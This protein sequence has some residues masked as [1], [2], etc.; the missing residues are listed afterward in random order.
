MEYR[1][2][3]KMLGTTIEI[4]VISDDWHIERRM[5]WIFDFFSSFEQEFSRF[6]PH[7]TLSM[8][9]TYKKWE[10]T[11]RFVKLLELSKELFKKT[12]WYFN[13]LV[14]ISA[15]GYS[16]D[17]E[18]WD[19]KK[20]IRD[21]N[22]DFENIR[23]D[24]KT[25]YLGENQ[26]LDFG[27]IWKWYAVDLASKFLLMFGYDNFFINAWWDIYGNGKMED[28]NP[29]SIWLENPFNGQLMWQVDL[30]NMAIATS[31][32]YIRNW[33]IGWE[34][35]HHILNP[36]S[37]KNDFAMA[38]VTVFAPTW[39]EA[40]AFTKALFNMDIR[41]SLDFIEKNWLAWFVVTRQNEILTTKDIEKTHNFRLY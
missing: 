34:K 19:F 39:A 23:I 6:L 36:K 3:R 38:S 9:N 20:I 41:T 30:N 35:Y 33:E 37:W 7:S 40:D 25:V 1:A 12:D 15:I 13:P 32:N 8:L 21:N 26:R 11:E 24:W 27:W 16:S 10:V 18:G 5:N 29:W 14:D 22:T 28:G 2:N 31:W 4:A 17:F